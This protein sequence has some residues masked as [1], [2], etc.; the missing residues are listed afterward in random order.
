MSNPVA[1]A[2]VSLKNSKTLVGGKL[3]LSFGRIDFVRSLSVL[4]ITKQD[5]Y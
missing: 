4:L 1:V 2:I 5:C 3:N